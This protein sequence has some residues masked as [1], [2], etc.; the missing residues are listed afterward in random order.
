MTTIL[1][2]L[3]NLTLAAVAAAS[4]AIFPQRCGCTDTNDSLSTA[5]A[6]IKDREAY[7]LGAKHAS[8][9]L[10]H[11][12]DEDMVQD[13]LLEVQARRSNIE[14]K[15]GSQSASDY[16]RGFIDHIRQNCDSLARIID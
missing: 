16:Q 13:D 9:L 4:F 3:K 6:K 2:R 15:L 8:Q 7:K 14:S 1:K 11:A 12:D 10:E 5:T